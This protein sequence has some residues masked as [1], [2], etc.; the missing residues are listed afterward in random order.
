MNESALK[1]IWLSGDIDLPEFQ[2][3][4]A[5]L[6]E[7]FTLLVH[8]GEPTNPAP[9]AMIDVR[10][11]WS[12]AA[13]ALVRKL[14]AELP[15][16]LMIQFLGQWCDGQG[17]TPGHI[18]GV[19]PLPWH[20]WETDLPS[21]LGIAA[22]DSSEVNV[23]VGIVAA[24][25]LAAQS[26]I[27]AIETCGAQ[28]VRLN[29]PADLRKVN[30]VFLDFTGSRNDLQA[31]QPW[32]TAA[33]GKPILAAASFARVYDV[34]SWQKRGIAAVLFKPFVLSRLKTTLKKYAQPN[35]AD[36]PRRGA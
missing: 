16:T 5:W 36:I 4:R 28:A 20:A 11:A 12:P 21:L 14:A 23:T 24:S 33:A 26:L 9:A 1:T 13:N 32:L 19:T 18:A 22:K 3:A 34:S 8:N 10:E 7:R 25:N 15:Q 27:D 17:R 29:E 35:G 30:V 6:E 31:L 2:S